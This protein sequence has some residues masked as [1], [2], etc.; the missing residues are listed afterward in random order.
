MT[1]LLPSRE[2]GWKRGERG[3]GVPVVGS[4]TSKMGPSSVPGLGVLPG[5]ALTL[6][7]VP[8]SPWAGAAVGVE[9]PSLAVPRKTAKPPQGGGQGAL[10]GSRAIF[11]GVP[12]ECGEPGWEPRPS[13]SPSALALACLAPLPHSPQGSHPPWALQV[14]ALSQRLE[15]ENTAPSPTP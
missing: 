5:K 10:G 4:G 12:P 8:P 7:T 2:L 1:G 11:S 14:T 3:R 9:G 6:G 13:G 15:A